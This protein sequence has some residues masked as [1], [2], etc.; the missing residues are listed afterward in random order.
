MIAVPESAYRRLACRVLDVVAETI[1]AYVR[2]YDLRF[3]V[4]WLGVQLE[5]PDGMMRKTPEHATSRSK[6]S[7]SSDRGF[8]SIPETRGTNPRVPPAGTFHARRC[9][10]MSYGNPHGDH[11]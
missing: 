2:V 11:E 3:L 6:R 4:S 7:R 8:G 10:T 1:D 5:S 9:P